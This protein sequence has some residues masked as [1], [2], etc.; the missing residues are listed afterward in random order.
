[1]YYGMV[2]IYGAL[3]LLVALP[4]GIFGADAFVRY[5]GESLLNLRV[6]SVLPPTWVFATQLVIA[7]IAPLFAALAPVLSGAR[8]TVRES[9]SDY[10]IGAAANTPSRGGARASLLKLPRLLTISLRNTFRRKGRLALTLITLTM[11]GAVFI[12]VLSARQG[13][14]RTL[15]VA[16]DYWKY[17]FDVNLASGYTIDSVSQTALNVPGVK[18]VESWGWGGATQVL[19]GRKDG[20]GFTISAPPATTV[21][22]KPIL[23]RGRWLQATDS[24]AIVLNTDVLKRLNDGASGA[25][26]DVGSTLEVKINGDRKAQLRVVGVVQGVLTG[27]IGYMNREGFMKIAQTGA[28]V[29]YIAVQTNTRDPQQHVVIAKALEEAFK[30]ANIKTSGTQQTAQTRAAIMQQFDIII[31]ILLAMAVLL[32]I[33][34]GLGLAGTMGINVLERTREIGVMRAIGA[35]NAAIR[36]IVTVEGVLIGA[37]S[38]LIGSALAVPFSYGIVLLLGQALEFEVFHAFSTLGLSLWLGIVVLIA[39]AASVMPAWNA[40]RLTVREVLAY[41]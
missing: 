30:R 2:L 1:M 31:Y 11:A 23:L 13:L 3:S 14:M 10:G 35:S 26:I 8:K 6:G 39:I 16:L 27:A 34:G 17:D 25:A 29:G 18:A 4:L 22:L 20:A 15:D 21:M 9:I 7:L 41:S 38:W 33:V 24:D 12:G 19:P 28:R 37:I 40:S 32:A 36:R 5:L